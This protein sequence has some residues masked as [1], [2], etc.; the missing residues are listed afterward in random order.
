M[1]PGKNTSIQQQGPLPPLLLRR[2]SD[3]YT[4]LCMSAFATLLVLPYWIHLGLVA[5]IPYLALS[6]LLSYIVVLINHNHSHVRT[7]RPSWANRA[8]D[9]A[10][11]ILR[12]APCT[13]IVAIHNLNHHAEVGHPTDFFWPGNAGQGIILFRPCVYVR[14]TYQRFRGGWRKYRNR[15]GSRRV[16]QI[17]AE[18]LVAISVLAIFFVVHWQVALVYVLFPMAI[19][20]IGLVLSNLFQHSGCDPTAPHTLGRNF[21]SPIENLLFLNGGYHSVHHLSPSIHWSDLQREHWRRFG[22]RVPRHLMQRSV[23]L[24]FFDRYILRG[25]RTGEIDDLPS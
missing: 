7:F 14:V 22:D 8:M 15:L 5:T 24:Y 21:T 17:T 10:L 11:S 19:G 13:L 6:S 23:I 9:F 12:G 4:L 16:R 20:N 3:L 2:W 1:E 25:F 18:T